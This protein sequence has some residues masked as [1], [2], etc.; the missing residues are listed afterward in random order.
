MQE[1]L[2]FKLLLDLTFGLSAV[3]CAFAIVIGGALV[4]AYTA[5]WLVQRVRK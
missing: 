3:V 1:L 2:W 4:V 5:I